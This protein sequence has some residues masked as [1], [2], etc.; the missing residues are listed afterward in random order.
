MILGTSTIFILF[1]IPFP[2]HLAHLASGDMEGRNH[3]DR[4]NRCV[5]VV[6][7]GVPALVTA[8]IVIHQLTRT[9]ALAGVSAYDDGVYFGAAVRLV[10][11]ELPYLDYV[12]VHPPGSTLAFAPLALVS[13]IVGTGNAFALARIAMAGVVVANVGLVSW[14]VRRHGILAMIGAGLV[15]ACFPLSVSAT[16]TMTLEPLLVLLSLSGLAAMFD[17]N[18]Q[19]RCGPA[20]RRAGLLLGLACL[21]KLWAMLVLVPVLVVCL[22][23]PGRRRECRSL[24]AGS[25]AGFGIVMVF[26]LLL[27]PVA[28]VQ[29]VI[30]AQI[31]RS[32]SSVWGFTVAER[33]VLLTG[34]GDFPNPVL[35]RRA[36][37]VAATFVVVVAAIWWMGRDH[38]RVGEWCLAATAMITVHAVLLVPADFYRYYT[39]FPVS[40]VAPIC[41]IT[42]GLAQRRVSGGASG[43]GQ[44]A[45]RMARG[46]TLSMGV[47][48]A[49]AAFAVLRTAVPYIEEYLAP[50]RNSS[51]L[52]ERLIPSGACVIFD[53]PAPSLL[54]D[55]FPV[56]LDDCPR[57]VDPFAVFLAENGGRTDATTEPF[58]ATFV[59]AWSGW[60]SHADYVVLVSPRSSFVPWTPELEAQFADTFQLVGS[61][62]RTFVYRRRG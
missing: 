45:I 18:G 3:V 36:V 49:G 53:E 58:D 21:V 14:F 56:G 42:L 32:S 16:H 62:D 51:A 31:G 35:A 60:L 37:I 8:V 44:R 24:I 48:M 47:L 2:V 5:F 29:N 23:S 27:D 11:G 43:A 7:C 22:V 13:T 17:A 28:V 30:G 50:S 19:A 39:Y 57:L 6:G 25:A 26:F 38:L 1:L 52:I 9:S 61:A 15:L 33:L 12:F 10:N 46:V 59:A 54:A 40:L 55:R 4:I 41:G 20:T 34:I